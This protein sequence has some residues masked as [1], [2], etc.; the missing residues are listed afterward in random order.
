MTTIAIIL[1]IL[2]MFISFTRLLSVAYPGNEDEK[3]EN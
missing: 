3:T 1:N 2:L